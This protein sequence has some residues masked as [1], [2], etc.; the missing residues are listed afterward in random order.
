MG[1]VFGLTPAPELFFQ[2]I[3]LTV[4]RVNFLKVSFIK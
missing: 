3:F 1:L 4:F 2:I